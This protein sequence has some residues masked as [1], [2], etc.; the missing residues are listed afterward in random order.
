MTHRHDTPSF[1]LVRRIRCLTSPTVV[2]RREAA[3]CL[4]ASRLN[5]CANGCGPCGKQTGFNWLTDRVQHHR[6]PF[7]QQADSG[8]VRNPS[9]CCWNHQ[10][11][12]IQELGLSH[13]ALLVG[14]K[15][16]IADNGPDQRA[17]RA[18]TRS[19]IVKASSK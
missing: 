6:V 1:L 3:P 4:I 12:L 2:L 14:E 8:M 13:Q 15:G 17:L 10:R 5:P 16:H 19:A 7:D 11:A 9:C 18:D